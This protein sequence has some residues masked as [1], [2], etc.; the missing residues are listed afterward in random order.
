MKVMELS[1]ADLQAYY[2]TLSNAGRAPKTQQWGVGSAR[3][4]GYKVAISHVPTV[5][6]RVRFLFGN[7]QLGHL[8][9]RE[10]SS[11]EAKVP[12][13]ETINSKMKE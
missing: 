3:V 12:V 8:N 2:N 11:A 6:E 5:S 10:A 9:P 13:Q 4:A 1:A 7:T